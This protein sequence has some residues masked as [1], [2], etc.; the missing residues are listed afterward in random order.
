MILDLHWS[1]PSNFAGNVQNPMADID[2]SI[3]F[4]TSVANTF[5]NNP[6]VLFELFNEPYFDP[7]SQP[8]GAFNSIDGKLPNTLANRMI[9]DGGT[10][11]YYFGLSTGTWGGKEQKVAYNWSVAGYQTLINAIR[12]T[13]ATNV[14]LCAGNRYS[15]DLT[16]WGQ[17]PPSD[18]AGQ[19]A[20]VIHLY[21]HGWPNDFR[22]GPGGSAQFDSMI[23]ANT[24]NY[25]LVVTEFGDEVGK[26]DAPFTRAVIA[27]LDLHGYSVT[28]WAWTTW[29][30]S[31]N[32]LLQD[33][34]KYTPTVG[35][36]QTYHDWAIN[37][38]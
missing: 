19:L 7:A 35:F 6:A 24:A 25:P 5:K 8:D 18:P 28:A 12:S 3:A 13:G 23:A 34:A 32:V 26:P 22:P 16:W 31:S 2:N 11:N 4:W 21:P 15:N 1:A 20:A 14:I 29:P 30:Q 27:W 17:N 37:H 10:A 33:V 9:R 38:R 36:G